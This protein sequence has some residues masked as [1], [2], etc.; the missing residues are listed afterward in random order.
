MRQKLIGAQSVAPRLGLMLLVIALLLV[1]LAQPVYASDF[2]GGTTV[3][4]N[5]NEVI[6]DDLFVSG[7]NVTVNGT[8]KGNL[9]ATGAV[10]TVNGH[11]EGSLFIAGRT[12]AQNG[13]VDGS[14]Y[15]GGYSFTLGE[16]AVIGR[17][18]NFGGF[19]LMTNGGSAV[20]R[21]LYGGGYQLLLNGRVEQDVNVGAA[22]LELNGTVG[23]D[24]RGSVGRAEEAA[25][26]YAMP[27]FEGAVPAVQPGLRVSPDAKVGGV[28]AVETTKVTVNTPPPPVYSLANPQLRWAIGE[29]L[30]LLIIGLLLLYVRPSFLQRA[31]NTVQERWLPSLGVGLIMIALAIVAIP[32]GIALIILLAV[33]S[34]WLTLGQLAGAVVGLGL[35]TLFFAIAL[36]WFAAAMVTKIIV[37][38]R[39]GDWLLARLATRESATGWSQALGL[40]L[41]LIVYVA[42][43]MIPFGIGAIIAFVITLIGL[44]AI[45]LGWGG[46]QPLQTARTS[47]PR[48]QTTEV[49]AV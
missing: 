44:G 42:L 21:S 35:T 20:G 45:Y 34:G 25:P 16:E 8:V 22:A 1:G 32:L 5:A 28:L 18:L 24:V 11:V 23:G 37:A 6:D 3:V 17:N 38:Y 30:T 49:P 40:S 36:F 43:R 15:V 14:T 19:S 41:G 48:V 33:L 7:E 9:F 4:I 47:S 31:S 13:R 10:V 27:Q 2:R 12:L 39:G 29:F 26:S 46:P